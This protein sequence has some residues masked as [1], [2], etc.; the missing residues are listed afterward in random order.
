MLS[1]LN[2]VIAIRYTPNAMREHAA[3]LWLRFST[4]HSYIS[5]LRVNDVELYSALSFECC[6]SQTKKAGKKG[7]PVDS[8]ML[9]FATGTD[10]SLLER[11]EQ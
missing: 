3:A 8:A 5:S 6:L 11:P 9:G 10:Y 7:K 4:R 2:E 1:S